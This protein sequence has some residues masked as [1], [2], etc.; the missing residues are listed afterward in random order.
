MCPTHLH[1]WTSVPI[2]LAPGFPPGRCVMITMTPE[3]VPKLSTSHASSHV[4]E[5]EP[6]AER[7]RDLP[8]VTGHRS[9]RP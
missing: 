7:L 5:E 9:P 2:S 6:E 8:K 4:S 1:F 3:L